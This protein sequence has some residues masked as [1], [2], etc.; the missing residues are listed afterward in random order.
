MIKLLKGDKIRK[1]MGE[2]AFNMITEKLAEDK[3]VEK[4]I[5]VYEEAIANHRR[6]QFEEIDNFFQWSGVP[7][8]KR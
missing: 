5:V 4:T 6:K 3:I 2:A 1:Q 7:S 8:S